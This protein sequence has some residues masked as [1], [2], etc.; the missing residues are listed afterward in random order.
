MNC[1]YLHYHI[2]HL[3]SFSSFTYS[4]LSF[5]FFLTYFHQFFFVNYFYR[6]NL[7]A[8]VTSLE[9]AIQMKRLTQ[10]LETRYVDDTL[11]PGKN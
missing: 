4:I 11:I 9:S 10:V 2:Y 1:T 8:P 5:P 6:D 3:H 7:E